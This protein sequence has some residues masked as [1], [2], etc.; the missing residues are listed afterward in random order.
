MQRH[1]CNQDHKISLIILALLTA[2][3]TGCNPKSETDQANPSHPKLN[4]G[5]REIKIG[6][7]VPLSGESGIFGKVMANASQVVVEQVNSAGGL[8]GRPLVLVTRDT[9]TVPQ[10]SLEAAQKLVA[11]DKVVGIIGARSSRNTIPVGKQIAAKVGIPLISPASTAPVI[12]NLADNDFVF[13]TVPSDAYQGIALAAIVNDKRFKKVAILYINDAYGQGMAKIFQESF[14]GYGGTITKS[15]AYEE[16]KKSYKE[17]LIQLKQGNPEALLFI[18]FPQ[19]GSIVLK[20]AVEGKFF[21]KFILTDGMKSSEMVQQVGG[22]NLQ[23]SFGTAPQSF[24]GTKTYIALKKA[25]EVQFGKMLPGATYLDTQYDATMLLA[26]AIQKAGSTKGEAIRDAL[27]E[28]A[29][30]PGIDITPGEWAKAVAAIKD[31]QDI[32]YVG[33]SG[34]VDLDQYGEV[35][36]T[37][38]HW[39]INEGKIE[40]VE[41][42]MVK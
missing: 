35:A 25:Y 21:K 1:Y 2:M 30:P 20:E 19:T 16:G 29:N 3:V 12:T 23:D 6:T 32:D 7:L 15:L 24:T 41:V 31:G 13:R 34:N 17:Q 42:M 36:G 8:L 27:R 9:K 26:L 33:A 11:E 5:V 14:E 28:V 4:T 40:T 38:G 22:Q 10:V 18:G 37:Y 39:K